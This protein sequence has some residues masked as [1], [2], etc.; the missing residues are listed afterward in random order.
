MADQKHMGLWTILGT[1][2]AAVLLTLV[3]DKVQ[4]AMLRRAPTPP[5]VVAAPTT[6]PWRPPG[7][8]TAAPEDLLKVFAD[9]EPV[10]PA[11]YALADLEKIFPAFR[12]Q[13]FDRAG[14]DHL[15]LPFRYSDPNHIGDP[16]EALALDVLISNDLDWAPGCYCER[17]ALFVFA[18]DKERF[19]ALRRQYTP[20]AIA[21]ALTDWRATHAIG[22][23]VIREAGGYKGTLEIYDCDGRLVHTRTFKPAR[24]FWDL[25][26]DMDVD[27]LTF[28]DAAPSP[29]LTAYLHQPRCQRPQSLIEL[30][31][32][33]FM[34]RLSPEQEAVIQDILKNDPSFSVVRHWYAN[35]CNWLRG[36]R[37]LWQTQNGTG[38]SSRVEPSSL[39]EFAPAFCPDKDL[40]VQMPDWIDFAA[41]LVSEDSPLVI[42]CRLNNMCYGSQTREAIVERGLKAAAK[43]PN[44]HDLLVA[45]ARNANDPA[46]SC[47]LLSSSLLDRSLTGT[48]RKDEE[49]TV[50]A[51]YCELVG[52]DDIA[53]ELMSRLGPEQSQGNLYL[54]LEVLCDGGRYREATQLYQLIQPT[55]VPTLAVWMLPR[56]AFSAAVTRDTRLLDG[57]L[58]DCQPVLAAHNMDDVF[59]AFRDALGGKTPDPEQYLHVGQPF[60]LATFWDALLVAYCDAK[61][62]KSQYHEFLSEAMYTW[63]TNRMLWIAEDDYQRRDPSDDIGAFYDYLGWF[64]GD[65]PWVA[66]AVA[67]FHQRGIPEKPID[68]AALRA[69]LQ[70]GINE[71]PRHAQIGDLNWAH[72]LA[73]WRVAACVHQLLDQNQAQDALQVAAQYRDFEHQARSPEKLY[74]ALELMRKVNQAIA[75]NGHG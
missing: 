34:D 33:A 65:D 45:L 47:S 26:G 22:G 55:S 52:R 1:V 44:S 11:Q 39:F 10:E 46:L 56:A 21:S 41:M 42:Y 35:Q 25:L 58:K 50:L 28:L 32:M 36:D 54:L 75:G 23:E 30:G 49:E 6:S 57:M 8:G 27:A 24:K 37:G 51:Q 7:T 64:F 68:V 70:Q 14:F 5:A 40:A 59:R 18:E 67:R 66:S 9:A 15:M 2:V 13:P 61:A 53:M 73:A 69:D 71:G 43:F 63:P 19:Q 29:I 4:R 74:I 48:G 17:H 62:G 12:H 16:N 31:S 38:L 3:I 72:L 60:E 20:E